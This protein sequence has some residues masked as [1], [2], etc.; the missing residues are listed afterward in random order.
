MNIL[1][2][3]LK[4]PYIE[5]KEELDAAYHRVMESAWYILGSEVEANLQPIA[6]LSIVSVSEMV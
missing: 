2:L 4:S 6:M 5:L 3:D 1:F